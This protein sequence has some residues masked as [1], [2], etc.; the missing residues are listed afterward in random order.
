MYVLISQ[1]NLGICDEGDLKVFEVESMQL[2]QQMHV[3]KVHVSI[4]VF[5]DCDVDDCDTTKEDH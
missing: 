4:K 1:P 5:D 2:I 3:K